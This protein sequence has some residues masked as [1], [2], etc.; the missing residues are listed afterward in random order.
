MITT[1]SKYNNIF[2]KKKKEKLLETH[3]AFKSNSRS[4][5]NTFKQK[6][7]KIKILNSQYSLIQLSL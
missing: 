2:L 6:D 7:V 3:L 4:F 1:P 5:Y